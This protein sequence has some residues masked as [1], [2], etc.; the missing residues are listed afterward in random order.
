MH[1]KRTL[2]LI[3]ARVRFAYT[4][5]SPS[6]AD[7]CALCPIEIEFDQFKISVIGSEIKVFTEEGNKLPLNGTTNCPV[8]DLRQWEGSSSQFSELFEETIICVD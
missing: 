1:I 4:N 6:S 2:K 3:C 7:E 5:K 8:V